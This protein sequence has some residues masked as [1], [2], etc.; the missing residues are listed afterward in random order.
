MS[1]AHS[2]AIE[3]RFHSTGK[4]ADANRHGA[5]CQPNSNRRKHKK[6]SRR[7]SKLSKHS[8]RRS[9]KNRSTQLRPAFEAAD[10][11]LEL[12]TQDGYESDYD[13]YVYQ[14]QYEGYEDRG[15]GD[16]RGWDN[17][18]WG[19]DWSSAPRPGACP[20]RT[21]NQTH[22]DVCWEEMKRTDIVYRSNDVVSDY[23]FVDALLHPRPLKKVD[24]SAFVVRATIGT[25][26]G[27]CINCIVSCIEAS[28]KYSPSGTAKRG[29]NCPR[30]SSPI[31]PDEIAAFLRSGQ[32]DETVANTLL[33]QI[34][35]AMARN[36]A[37]Q[38][39]QRPASFVKCARETCTNEFLFE[40]STTKCSLVVCTECQ[41]E[42]CV[43]CRGAYHYGRSCQE[44]VADNESLAWRHANTRACPDC[45][46]SIEKNGGCNHH[47]C[48]KCDNSYD[49]QSAP[50]G[51]FGVDRMD[52]V[53]ESRADDEK[54]LA[55]ATKPEPEQKS[56]AAAS[57][58]ASASVTAT[59]IWMQSIRI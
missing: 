26:T 41:F 44:N 43:V 18:G 56:C 10:Q 59:P 49:W 30:C 22:C 6:H 1:E 34:D 15:W 57:A 8:G 53:V 21:G 33:V 3:E 28:V 40:W 11:W 50:R 4:S 37:I 29:M 14:N 45:F 31:T 42:N 48:N 39:A 23:S 51:I 35:S 16:D 9:G 32:A 58:S 47:S 12:S 20:P 19:D 46:V 17:A 5:D 38:A 7:N 52:E 36:V 24:M 2:I 27:C 13:Y 25:E 54:K 55:A